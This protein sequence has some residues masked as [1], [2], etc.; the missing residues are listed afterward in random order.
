MPTYI[1]RTDLSLSDI[2]FKLNYECDISEIDLRT[3]ME[4][5]KD[6][7]HFVKQN[8][9]KTYNFYEVE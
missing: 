2:A 1:V 8:T 7:L 3:P 5:L 4:S 9:G 6:F